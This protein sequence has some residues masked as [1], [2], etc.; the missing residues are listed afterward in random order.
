[1]NRLSAKLA[2]GIIPLIFAS[3]PAFAGDLPVE[4]PAP[5]AHWSA[6]IGSGHVSG[7]VAP[8]A[9]PA[10]ATP[11]PTH[12]TARVGTG[13]PSERAESSRPATPNPA[14]RLSRIGEGHW[15]SKVGTARA[16][17]SN[18]LIAARTNAGS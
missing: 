5:A 6:S 15:T 10:G 8:K 14:A 4:R 2:I 1:M 17:E 13:R 9:T 18:S 16:F 3:I 12:W 7:G 11:A